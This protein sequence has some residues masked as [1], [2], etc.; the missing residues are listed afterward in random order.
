MGIGKILEKPDSIAFLFYKGVESAIK[1]ANDA[2]AYGGRGKFTDDFLE[3]A[4][5]SVVEKY[6][7]GSI[8]RKL[9]VNAAMSMPWPDMLKIACD[10]LLDLGRKEDGSYWSTKD[11]IL[12]S[13]KKYIGE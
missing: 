8:K 9:M 4:F 13:L 2:D 3:D 1:A 7:A 5:N 6:S 10:I 12:G 11:T